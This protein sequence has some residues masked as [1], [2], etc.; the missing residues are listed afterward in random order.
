MLRNLLALLV[1][2]LS[3]AFAAHAQT[4]HDPDFWRQI[5]KS[6]YAV[7]QGQNPFPLAQE[8]VGLFSSPDPELRD[9][10]AYSILYSWI[11]KPELF[12]PPELVTL[13]TECQTNL[14][15]GLGEQGTNSVLQRSFSAL[16][17]SLLAKRDAKSPFL[18]DAQFHSLVVAAISYLTAEQDLRGYDAKLG[19]IHATAHTADLLAELGANPRLTRDEQIHIL[20]AIAERL[21]TAPQVYI[22]GE[23]SRLALAVLSIMRRHDF[24]PATFNTWLDGLQ[25][26]DRSVWTV[27]PLTPEALAHF[28]NRTYMLD[29]IVGRMPLEPIP[30]T[31]NQPRDRILEMLRDR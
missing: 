3:A 10:L 22:Q 20:S 4:S 27:K 17:L 26:A 9:D 24:D 11:R 6:H 31:L 1:L 5:A 12:T 30:P 13:T 7:P 21:Q 8:L 15:H 29:A 19:W 14:Q 2:L 23:Q 18:S 16:G 28:Q 25:S